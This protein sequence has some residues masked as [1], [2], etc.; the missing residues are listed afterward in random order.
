[1]YRIE[2]VLDVEIKS[3]KRDSLSLRLIKL[4]L[5]HLVPVCFGQLIKRILLPGF[6]YYKNNPIIVAYSNTLVPNLHVTIK[7]I[8]SINCYIYIFLWKFSNIL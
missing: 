6:T 3:K 7:R 8:M 2:G 5:S 1:M 4:V